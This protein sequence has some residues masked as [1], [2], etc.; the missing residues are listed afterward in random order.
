LKL[1]NILASIIINLF[2]L[3]YCKASD[4]EYLYREEPEI[5]GMLLR[6]YA[7]DFIQRECLKDARI[8]IDEAIKC[9]SSV[10]TICKTC[11]LLYRIDNADRALAL[12]MRVPEFTA[13]YKFELHDAITLLETHHPEQKALISSLKRRIS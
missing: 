9:V 13:A 10:F 6:F 7:K 1:V 8:M 3:T 4:L 12:L 2:S 11:E 5:R